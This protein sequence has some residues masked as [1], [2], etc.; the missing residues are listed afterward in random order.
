MVEL[1]IRYALSIKE[2]NRIVLG[3]KNHSQYKSTEAI[4]SKG[5]LSYDVFHEITSHI[6]CS[7][8]MGADN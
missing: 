2:A 7:W 1:A 5:P 8:N 4:L 6:M 3:G